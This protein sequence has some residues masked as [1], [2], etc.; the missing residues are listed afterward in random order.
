MNS[1][2]Q[3][4]SYEANWRP[5]PN[6][7]QSVSPRQPGRSMS[8]DLADRYSFRIQPFDDCRVSEGIRTPDPW[9]HNP[10]LYPLSYAH[11]RPLRPRAGLAAQANAPGRNRTCNPKLRRLVLYPIELRA[12]VWRWSGREDL[13]LR[14]PAPK[15]GA[16]NQAALRP[17][18]VPTTR[19]RPRRSTE[20]LAHRGQK[21]KRVHDDHCSWRNPVLGI[22]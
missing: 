19:N 5:E 22:S 17:E 6:G 1:D 12:P 15:A 10:V 7:I 4:S 21:R 14:P 18:P 2:V 20:F 13:N 16:L 8:L 9:G 11:H 3:N